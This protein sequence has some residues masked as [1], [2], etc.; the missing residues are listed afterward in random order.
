MPSDAFHDLAEE[1][2][3]D[4]IHDDDVGD[5]GVGDDGGDVH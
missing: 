3:D 1:M 2:D 5:D 4:G